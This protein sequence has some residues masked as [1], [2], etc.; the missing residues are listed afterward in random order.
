MKVKIPTLAKNARMGHPLQS[1]YKTISNHFK[2][3]FAVSSKTL[4]AHFEPAN[5]I[6]ISDS[7]GT[8][9]ILVVGG[10][11]IAVHGERSR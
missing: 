2:D 6:G 7:L 5:K 3:T 9:Y 4:L 11:G 10:T 1:H 8:T